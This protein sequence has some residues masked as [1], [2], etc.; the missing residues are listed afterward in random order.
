MNITIFGFIVC[1]LL[2]QHNNV[3]DMHDQGCL[4]VSTTYFERKTVPN[5][6]IEA[7][8][9]NDID[10]DIGFWVG[11]SPEGV[12]ESV[13]SLLPMSVVPKSFQNDF[14]AMEVV[15]KNG[16]KHVIFRGLATVVN[17]TDFKL[18]I[19]VCHVSLIHGHGPSVV[20]EIFENQRYHPISGWNNKWPGFRSDDPGRW[21]TM[22][23]SYSSKVS[24]LE[25]YC[26]NIMCLFLFLN[27]YYNVY[28]HPP[29]DW[30]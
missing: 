22:D 10:R 9:E 14:I 26:F 11:L 3:E 18:D 12:W 16:K 27:Y 24:V 30:F 1:V 19:S 6:K 8:N 21:S 13:R 15:M 28:F 23:F 25:E 5:L 2:V 17:D 4:L 20:E 7:E 29:L